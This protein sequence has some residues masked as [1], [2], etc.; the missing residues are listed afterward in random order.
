MLS[1]EQEDILTG[2]FYKEAPYNYVLSF[3]PEKPAGYKGL[4]SYDE[5]VCV[6]YGNTEDYYDALETMLHEIAHARIQKTHT[7]EWE[8]E[9][10]RLLTKYNFPRHLAG[11]GTIMGPNVRAYRDGK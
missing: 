7:D 4:C 10:V 2:I 6:V 9:L 8:K 11:R 5:Q 1:E 3:D